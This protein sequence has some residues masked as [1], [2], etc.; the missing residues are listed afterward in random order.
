MNVVALIQKHEGYRR[1]PYRC[2]AG[3]LTVGY[4]RNLDDVGIDNEEAT[5]L[6]HRDIED[7]VADLQRE[8]Y[9]NLINEVRQ[10][11]LIDMRFNLGRGGFIAFRR[12]RDALAKDDFM[13]AAAEMRDSQWFRQVG[14]RSRRLV[15]M[16]E[17][18]EW[19]SDI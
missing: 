10:A 1:T 15:K 11:V 6:L 13:G 7:A 4:G 16:M 18:G 14:T 17:T 2:P 19:P 9:W 3:K 5:Y 12:M 8:P